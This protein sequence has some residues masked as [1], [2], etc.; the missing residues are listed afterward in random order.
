VRAVNALL[1]TVQGG[2]AAADGL[3]ASALAGLEAARALDGMAR[4]LSAADLFPGVALTPGSSADALTG[5]A[6]PPGIAA[7]TLG[8]QA[9]AGTS[10]ADALP[11]AAL[12]G[13][14]AAETLPGTL[15][16]ET[17]DLNAWPNLA[18]ENRYRI[19]RDGRRI[20]EPRKWRTA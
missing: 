17:D 10:A 8:G 2:L 4:C 15:R 20:T 18:P 19:D 5:S 1:S 3:S 6:V 13:R 16:P 14:Q 12:S 9:L 11:G 7:E